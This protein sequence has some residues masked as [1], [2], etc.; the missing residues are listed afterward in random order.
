MTTL[1]SI[2]TTLSGSQG[3]L[4]ILTVSQLPTALEAANMMLRYCDEITLIGIVT[5]PDH[6]SILV[7]GEAGYVRSAQNAAMQM[8]RKTQIEASQVFVV[9]PHEQLLDWLETVL[10]D[11]IPGVVVL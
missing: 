9:R 10:G 1:D 4:G 2:R 11:R 7:A 8:L 3:A 6:V 5:R